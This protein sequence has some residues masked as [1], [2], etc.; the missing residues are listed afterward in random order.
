MRNVV[1]ALASLGAGSVLNFYGWSF[2]NL[3]ILP[4]LALT[5]GLTFWWVAAERRARPGLAPA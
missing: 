2:V 4:L 5:A 3:A 1:S